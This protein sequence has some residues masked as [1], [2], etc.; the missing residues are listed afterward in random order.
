MDLVSKL[1]NKVISEV[2]SSESNKTSYLVCLITLFWLK[3]FVVAYEGIWAF[4]VAQ[5]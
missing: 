4:L 1:Q 5:W 2:Q 3:L